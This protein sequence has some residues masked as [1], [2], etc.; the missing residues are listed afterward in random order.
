MK[1]KIE[2]D[3]VGNEKIF[4]DLESALNFASRLD[5]GFHCM[6]DGS[7][8]LECGLNYFTGKWESVVY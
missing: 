8:F 4:N 6:V 1:M 5:C 3:Y 7:P 2:I